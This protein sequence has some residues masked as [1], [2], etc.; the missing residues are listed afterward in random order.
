ME[1]YGYIGAIVGNIVWIALAAGVA[2][3]VVLAPHWGLRDRWRIW[4]RQKYRRQLEDA[5]KHLLALSERGQIGSAESLGGALGLSLR[6]VF[7]LIQRMETRGVTHSSGG[8]IELTSEGERWALQVV[9][10]HRLWERYLADEAGMPLGRVHGAAERA[11]HGMSAERLDEL[12][13]QLGH[14]T[15]DPHGDPI[16]SR[17]GILESLGATPLTDWET[18]KKAYIVHVEDEPDVV[19][20]QI[21]AIGL[22]PGDPI[23]VL[24]RGPDF[25]TISHAETEHRMAPVV[26]GNIHVRAAA[27][28]PS[29]PADAITLAQLADGEEADV[30]GIDPSY[31]GFARRR[32]LDLG[33]TP[34]ARVRTELDN[35]FGD[36]RAYRIRGTLVALRGDQAKLIWVRPVNGARQEHVA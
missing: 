31:R 9:R 12:E 15:S 10:A 20:R 30:V 11:E 2:W 21:L 13:A 24:E 23:R 26:A 4:R 7:R 29:K 36:P 33:L 6:D 17:D 28:A 34:A 35:A 19:L 3:V 32:L 1:I 25:V 5:L 16:P 27:V 22:K 14:P 18:G 8:G